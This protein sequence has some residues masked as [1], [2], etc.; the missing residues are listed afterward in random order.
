MSTH[1]TDTSDK[2][3]PGHKKTK[4][5]DKVVKTKEQKEALWELYKQMDG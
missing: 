1:E 3:E 5:G 4:A 2:S